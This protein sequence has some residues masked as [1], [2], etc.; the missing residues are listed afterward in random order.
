MNL[1]K[2]ISMEVERDASIKATEIVI[3]NHDIKT[4]KEGNGV[5]LLCYEDGRIAVI[6]V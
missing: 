6:V 1:P 4:N 3:V 5:Q 2:N